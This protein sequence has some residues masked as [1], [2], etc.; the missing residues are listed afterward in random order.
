M[1]IGE[2]FILRGVRENNLK[3]LDITLD[4]NKLIVVTGVSGSGKSTLAFDTIYAEGGRRY[5]E[6]FSPYTRQFLDKLHQPELDSVEGVRPALALEQRN[7]TTASRSTVGT[8]TEIND[9]LK[10][11]WPHLA[12]GYCPKCQQQ[13]RRHTAVDVCLEIVKL[14]E[15]G[16]APVT[17]AFSLP[18]RKDLSIEAYRDVI[19]SQGF[20]RMIDPQ[21]GEVSRIQDLVEGS[22]KKRKELFIAL[23]RVSAPKEERDLKRALIPS[24][25]QAYQFGKGALTLFSLKNG[26]VSQLRL[27]EAPSCAQCEVVLPVPRPSMFS[28]NSAL[29]ACKTCHGFG[30]VLDLDLNRCVP[31]SA[32]SIKEGAV[33]CWNSPSTKSEFKELLAFCEE[34]GI[35]TTAPWRELSEREKHL[36]FRGTGR[37]KGF[38][39]LQ[40]WFDWLKTKRHKMH[41]RILISRFRSETTCLD[42]GGG[43]LQPEAALFRVDEKTLQD[44][45]QIPFGELLTWFDDLCERYQEHEALEVPL[46]EIR[47][48]LQYLN[49]IGL[50]YLTLDRQSRT[51]SGGEFQRVNLTSILGSRL[52]NTA[53]VLDEPT[54]GLHPRDT[55]KLIE[56]LKMLRDRGNTL[57]V[58]EHEP[59]VMLAADEVLDLGPLAGEKGGEILYQGSLEG[60]TE[61]KNSLTADFLSGRLKIERAQ[62][63]V[64]KS[65]GKKISRHLFIEK[66]NL[67]NLKDVSVKIP[68]EK[69][70]VVTGVSGSGK[71]TLVHRCIYDG[72][73]AILGGDAESGLNVRSIRGLDALDDI[74]LIDQSPIGKTPRS[75]PATYTGC[76]D[77]IR[78]LLAESPRAIELGLGKSAF[79][80]NVDGGRCPQC[81][82]AGYERVEMQFLADV[83]VECEKCGGS[84]FKDSVLSVS[85]GGKNVQ[86]LLEMSLEE[87]VHFFEALEDAKKGEKLKQLLAPMLELGL[88]YLRLGQ[89]LSE[90]SGGEAQR[91][92]LASFLMEKKPGKFMFILDEPTTGLHPYNIQFLLKTFE[93]LLEREH[94]ILCVEHNKEL[95]R[96]ADWV[97]DLGPE[98]GKGGGEIVCEGTPE[99]LLASAE[100]VRS[101][102][103]IAELERSEGSYLAP[104]VKKKSPPKGVVVPKRREP[105]V[106]HPISV[107][108]ARHHNLK[109]ISVEIPSGK[110][111]VMTGVSGSGKSTL[112][113]DILFQEGQRRYIDCL[114][115]YA[116]QYITHLSRADVDRVDRIPPTIAV[117][118]KTAPP[119]GV[120]T[121]G[122]TTEIYQFLR[123][124]YSKVG[125]QHCPTHGLPI[126]G[127]S[128]ELI[129]EEILRESK[130]KRAFILAPAVSGRKGYYNDL[131]Q[132]AFRADLREARVDG[133]FI[134][135]T[136][137]TR[138]ERHKL[139]WI[140]LLIASFSEQK[141][142]EEM[143]AEAVEQALLWSGGTVELVLG[144]RKNDP[145]VFSTERV[146]PTC[147]RGF[148]ELDPQDFSFRS[149]RGVCSRCAGRGF[150]GEDD[151][152]DRVVCPT[153]DGAR[154][155]ETGRSVT[156]FGS[157]IFELAKMTAPELREKLRSFKFSPRLMPVVEPVLRELNH[158]L[159]VIDSV[160]L[161]YLSLDRDAST[162]SGGEAQRL[163]LARTLGSPLTGI[164]YVLDEPTIG[165]HPQDHEKLME[166][167]L[168]LRDR[169]NTV[170]VV[171]HDEETICLAD[172][173]IDMGPVG[174]ANGGH[175]VAE[176][177]P[178]ELLSF[179][180]SKTG[181]ALKERMTG[182]GRSAGK[183]RKL[184]EFLLLEGASANNLKAV[185][186]KFP[187]AALTVICGVSGAGKS[188]LIHGSLVPAIFDEF[189]EKSSKKTKTYKSLKNHDSLEKYL[190]IDQSP[191]GKTSSSC[192]ASY[193]GIFDEIRKLFALIPESQARGWNASYFSYNSGKG[194]CSNCEGKGFLKVPMS[195]LPDAVAEC[196]ACNGLRYSE[197]TLE[198][199]Y[200]GFS[201]GEILK[202]TMSEAKEIFA[203]HKFIRR[204]LDYVTDL[205][206][207]YLSL[208]QPTHTLSGGE[209]QR[210]KLA[211]E[212]GSREATKTLYILDEPTI[213][214]HMTDID[215]LMNVIQKLIDRGNSVIVIEHNLDVIAAADYLIEMGPGPGA[216]GGTIIFSGT[217]EEMLKRKFSSPTRDALKSGRTRMLIDNLASNP[218]HFPID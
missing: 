162:L 208:G 122:T 159:E 80:F 52:T 61:A 94:S 153:C 109:N 22:T 204:T 214:L 5:I 2:K 100:V 117:S 154:V 54:I 38:A 45:W 29:G 28:F 174:G 3:N 107:V 17:L 172:H 30:K 105:E 111:T 19:S 211:M 218:I 203:N 177:S 119:H 140:S 146:C 75:N 6:T 142:N 216:D 199:T 134:S 206:I 39:G 74:I 88:G 147:R 76:W 55:A 21:T 157:R 209:I 108:G 103:T 135:I 200:Q 141:K 53:L 196:E 193:L 151:G 64:K 198:I 197:P 18:L 101:S 145:I 48:R 33:H 205:G 160:G 187:L 116:R 102:R 180:E 158:R 69:F 130:G 42:C 167:L 179:P 213:G 46:E 92:K 186:A 195:F 138:L 14:L 79:S 37:K 181:M 104:I 47:T 15:S 168:S 165:L 73:K 163:R 194:K 169:G 36:I 183:R 125:L 170:V 99:E 10:I 113:F 59:E 191:V 190:E 124:I 207:G 58:V 120:S 173:V 8:A 155:G 215:K 63:E 11:I 66:A 24:V 12:K 23:D 212:L 106:P 56:A 49:Q 185:S 68:L 16:A 1:A 91:V 123:L 67:H 188:S 84:R 182:G 78:D 62:R 144:D 121:I 71:S 133:K 77:L 85:L 9:Y 126:Q 27:T 25:L 41:V 50:N 201:I 150:I 112:A 202:K 152:V 132:R 129:C 81:Q 166:I 164:C 4:H 110:L 128:K 70:V 44:V 97:I 178:A 127:L 149:G 184:E 26:E 31:N 65:K 32:K 161:G 210:L 86:Q 13:V 175:V 20:V 34:E 118:Q 90:L 51:L 136:D 176:G 137:E 83:F 139:H 171:E 93:K 89:P 148:R 98:G 7:R 57:V 143:L 72:A 156:L 189:G 35:S 131:F 87:S 43:R 40:G 217:P 60:L 114:S 82:G 192:P 96:A 115:P 95:I